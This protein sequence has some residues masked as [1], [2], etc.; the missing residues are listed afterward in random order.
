V[1]TA[2]SAAECGRLSVP[3]Q[4]T[5]HTNQACS[6]PRHGPRPGS[7]VVRPR[8]AATPAHCDVLDP[9]GVLIQGRYTLTPARAA[10]QGLRAAL[11]AALFRTGEQSRDFAVVLATNR[12]ADLDP[13]VLDRMDE[14]L[15][16]PLPGAAERRRILQ[17]YLD[18]YLSRAGTAAG[19]PLPPPLLPSGSARFA[20]ICGRCGCCG[21]LR[22][23]GA[24]TRGRA[25][26]G[27]AAAEQGFAA[28]MTAWLRGRSGAP[29]RIE[30]RDID[31]ALLDEA[32]TA[33]EG[34]S[35]RE[36]AKLVA[37]MQARRRAPACM[38]CLCAGRL[39]AG[40]ERA[41]ML[42]PP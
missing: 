30:L 26:G 41:C 32:A 2:S 19:A 37:S 24:R 11:N 31:A 12:P 16:F 22:S 39:R 40:A 23:S 14:A 1:V 34:F 25:G 13:A 8:G 29:D 35:G 42:A 33:T 18:S 27:G 3:N 7:A 21:H 36:L 6:L 15:E 28:R 10:A 20:L 4:Q 17:I 38:A 5:W 9:P